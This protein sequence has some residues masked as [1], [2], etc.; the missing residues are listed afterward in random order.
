MLDNYWISV[1]PEKNVTYR[2]ELDQVRAH[3]KPKYNGDGYVYAFFVSNQV[4]YL[5]E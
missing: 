5:R 1:D 2:I 3:N 4:F